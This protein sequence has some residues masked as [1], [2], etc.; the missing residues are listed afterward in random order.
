MLIDAAVELCERQGFER[1]TVDQIAAIADVSPR[2]FSR[3]FA[4]KDAIALE[5]IDDVLELTAVILAKQPADLNHFQALFRSFI[6]MCT[7]TKAA[8]SG[9]LTAEQLMCTARIIMTS[10]A[11]RQAAVEFSPNAMNVELAKR[12]D[13]GVD[14]RRVKLVWAVWT[15]IV[16]N[17]LSDVSGEAEDWGSLGIDDVIARVETAFTEFIGLI[18]DIPQGV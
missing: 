4:T 14:D 7:N 1:T 16:M 9:D 12:M 8:R 17:A 11:L 18:G 3:Y 6:E 13:V 2:T 10:Q 15:S 5:L